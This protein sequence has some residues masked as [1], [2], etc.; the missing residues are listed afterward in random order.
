MYLVALVVVAMTR[1]AAG[2]PPGLSMVSASTAAINSRSAGFA[3][4]YAQTFPRLMQWVVMLLMLVGA[5]S[6]GTAGGIGL[7]TISTFWRRESGRARGE[8]PGRAFGMAAAWMGTYLLFVATCFGA[9]LYTNADVRAD[10][11][12]FETISGVGNSGLSFDR[13]ILVSPGL[14]IM[15]D[16]ML[17]GR[18]LPLGMLWWLAARRERMTVLI[19]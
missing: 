13:V 6:A 18:L 11:L 9:L 17:V 10:V 2:G 7:T 15:T 14:D 12:L 3:R 8:N 16:A 5:G 4:E 1:L 19:G